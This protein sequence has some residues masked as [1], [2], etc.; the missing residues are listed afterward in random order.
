R[1][2]CIALRIGRTA[3]HGIVMAADNVDP[4]DRFRLITFQRCDDIRNNGWTENARRFLLLVRLLFNSHA[5]TSFFR[6]LQELTV[7]PVASGADTAVGIVLYGE[8][9]TSAKG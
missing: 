3:A 6:S 1:S 4:T 2:R 8:R 7:K 5:A 9:V